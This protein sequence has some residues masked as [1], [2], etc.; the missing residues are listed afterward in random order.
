MSRNLILV[1]LALVIWGIGE[2]MFLYFQP[3]YLQQLGANP[4]L[5]GS[6]LGGIGLLM[7][8]VYLP[9][10]YLS[11]HIGRRPM[12]IA[13]W[14]MGT[15]STGIMALAN[16]LPIFV[17]GMAL[18]GMTSFVVVP[19]GSYV[20]AARGKMSVAR[21]LTLISATYNIGA[22]LGPLIGGWV[23]EMLG[24]RRSFSIA[25]ILFIISTL[26]IL[27]IQ[28][29][30]VEH[31]DPDQ[32]GSRLRQILTPVFIR[33]LGVVFVVIFAMY[34]SQPLSQNFLQNERG[35][36]LSEIGQVISLRSV[37]IV[38]F[39]LV[40]GQLAVRRGFLLA[41]ASMLLFNLF[42][43][44]GNSMLWYRLGYFFLG[45]FQT[46]RSLATAQGR[47]LLTRQNMGVGYGLIE[48]FGA[49]GLI[50]APPI[51]GWLYSNNPESIYTTGLV[52]IGIA[53]IV[54]I[55]FTPRQIKPSD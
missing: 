29:Q 36:N 6:I 19:L 13:S 21:A 54:T 55:I 7:T 39:N 2:G 20:T 9:A 10:G 52:L 41:Q 18:Y 25:F 23:G 38:V 24:L 32:K 37:G 53:I 27:F 1:A 22:I 47:A 11:D 14:L 33:Y 31:R 28:S 45:S 16:S 35:L 12:L 3:L 44:L 15:V 5:I 43:W 50:L 42:I 34:L 8:L 49:M 26:V 48:T 17:I 4:V 46:S 51:A 40:L 30:P